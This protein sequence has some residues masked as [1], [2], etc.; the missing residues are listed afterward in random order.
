MRFENTDKSVFTNKKS[1]IRRW[2]LSEV[3]NFP[4]RMTQK[5]LLIWWSE[6]KVQFFWKTKKFDQ[7]GLQAYYFGN[8]IK[9]IVV[10][11]VSSSF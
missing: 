4:I 10:L 1:L 8:M 2:V 9:T 7:L 6:Q 5:I 11:V 3:C